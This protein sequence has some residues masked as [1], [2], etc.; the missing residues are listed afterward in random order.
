MKSANRKPA[1]SLMA[2]IVAAF[3]STV[4]YSIANLCEQASLAGARIEPHLE[5]LERE[6][7]KR[8]PGPLTETQYTAVRAQILENLPEELRTA[9][10]DFQDQGS[11]LSA[12]REQVA[13]Q[14]G[15]EIGRML[16]RGGAR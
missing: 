7:Y 5:A 11:A 3:R 12:A 15:I 9:F 8:L 10:V 14:V 2:T 6:A 1:S 16:E 4:P 13:F